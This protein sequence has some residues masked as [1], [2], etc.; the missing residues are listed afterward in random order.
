MLNFKREKNNVPKYLKKHKNEPARD[1]NSAALNKAKKNIYWQAGLAMVTIV[2]T[3]VIAFA[4]T[5]A[6][7]TNIVQTSGLVFEAE[8]WGFEG[9]IKVNNDP[10]VA[11]PGDDGVIHLEVENDSE[12]LIAV[13]VN[14]SKARMAEEMQQR[15]YFYVDT[16]QTRN[17]ETMDRVYLNN[18]EGYTYTLFSN[19]KLTLTEEMHNGAQ[20][21]WQW[22]YDVL[23][24]YVYGTEVTDPDGETTV[25]IAE[26]LRPIEYNYDEATTTFATDENGV[27]SM[28]LETVDGKTSVNKFLVNFSKTDGYEGTIDTSKKLDSGFYPV[29]VKTDADDN[30]YGVYA[31][32]CNYAEIQMANQVDTALGQAAAEGENKQQYEAQLTISAQKNKNNVVNVTSLAG[33]YAAMELG[34]ADVI[35]LSSNITVPSE[36]SLTIA[37]GQR[38][39]LDL[40]GYT[41]TSENTK[42]AIKVAEGGALTMIN[43]IVD[44]TEAG[45]SNG[46]YAVGAEVMLSDVDIVGCNVGLRVTDDNGTEA[47]DSKVHLLNCEIEANSYGIIVKGNGSDSEHLTQ[48]IVEG[49]K[50]TT[51]SVGISGNGSSDQDGTDI[52]IINSTIEG[53][54]QDD[55]KNN[56]ITTGIY[57][58]Q[59]NGKLTVYKSKISAYTGIAIKGGSVS[60]VDST[61]EGFG[62]KQEAELKNSGCADTGDGIYIEANYSGDILLE[63]SG[64]SKITSVNSDSLQV[65]EDDKPNVTVKIYSGVFD[66]AQPVTYIAEGSEQKDSTV[67]VKG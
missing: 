43:G 57:H 24:Y 21:K 11:G 13:G 5:S 52:Q 60:V 30:R 41:I 53:R 29:A 19:G 6:W 44:G 54:K 2:L 63:I 10:I 47:R 27:P 4:M 40:N 42:N 1:A 56:L 25:N 45:T 16:Q 28:A 26:Y 62:E 35:Q 48:V 31:Y 22:V 50:I 3:I 55:E 33:V 23:G 61:V 14:I 18:Q 49:C 34:E 39:M 51:D 38:V 15:L 17:G 37:K 32:L 58:P 8:A 66:E 20:L 7:Y 59:A 12:N 46:I 65:L 64:G 36:E 9:N 67:T